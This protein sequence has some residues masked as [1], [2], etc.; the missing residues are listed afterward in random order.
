MW[1]EVF[2]GL[3]WET[4]KAEL[5]EHSEPTVCTV[6][7]ILLLEPSWCCLAQGL[8]PGSRHTTRDPLPQSGKPSS[9]EV[10][11]LPSHL[12]LLPAKIPSAWGPSSCQ[13]MT[14]SQ[15]VISCWL[16]LASSQCCHL[17]G[18][19]MI[20]KATEACSLPAEL[21]KAGATWAWRLRRA[22]LCSG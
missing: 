11:H 2:Q 15:K 20:P 13:K 4:P 9:T 3:F 6:L 1:A 8:L 17:G 16:A 12:I 7:A 22:A 5:L 10:H 18:R 14:R 19:A 21:L